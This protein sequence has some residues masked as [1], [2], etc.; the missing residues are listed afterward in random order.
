VNGRSGI[1][2]VRPPPAAR[3][4]LSGDLLSKLVGDPLSGLTFKLGDFFFIKLEQCGRR[5]P[6]LGLE[7]PKPLS[8]AILQILS[9]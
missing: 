2:L 6:E 4:W 5:E 7:A 8:Q 9:S 1:A 3:V